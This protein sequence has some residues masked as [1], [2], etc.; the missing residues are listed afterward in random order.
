MSSTAQGPSP[1]S[2][3]KMCWST[4]HSWA[5]LAVLGCSVFGESWWGWGTVIVL[6]ER[7]GREGETVGQVMRGTGGWRAG[8]G[9]SLDP[10]HLLPLSISDSPL[11]IQEDLDVSADPF[12]VIWETAYSLCWNDII[13]TEIDVPCYTIRKIINV[14]CVNYRALPSL[15]FQ[16]NPAELHWAPVTISSQT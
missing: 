12:L 10:L 9:I 11:L 2:N 6:M 16:S 15:L 7:L 8:G 4:P 14:L 3:L 13:H 1:D 5:L